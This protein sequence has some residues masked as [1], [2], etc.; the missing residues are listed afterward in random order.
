MARSMVSNQA[1]NRLTIEET[2]VFYLTTGIN[3]QLQCRSECDA[4]CVFFFLPTRTLKRGE[5]KCQKML[6][7]SDV[8]CECADNGSLSDKL[9]ITP[10][11]FKWYATFY[12][13]LSIHPR[14]QSM[15]HGIKKMPLCIPNT[16]KTVNMYSKTVTSFFFTAWTF[17]QLF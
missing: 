8:N 2:S 17:I 7:L 5:M 13:I 12:V 16:L 9:V 15:Q 3:F 4:I 10:P 14:V 11:I 6:S 1:K